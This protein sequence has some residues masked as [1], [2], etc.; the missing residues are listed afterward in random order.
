MH[1]WGS[2]A[3]A[4]AICNSRNMFLCLPRNMLL[5]LQVGLCVFLFQ[6]LFTDS[7]SVRNKFKAGFLVGVMDFL[8]YTKSPWQ[9]TDFYQEVETGEDG[10]NLS[11][12]TCTMYKDRRLRTNIYIGIHIHV[13][14]YIYLILKGHFY[15]ND[16]ILIFKHF[17]NCPVGIVHEGTWSNKRCLIR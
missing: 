17:P 8:C 1:I 15:N 13:Y 7:S 9:L 14:K 4:Y 5:W 6:V 3:P 11:Q 2:Q 10:L 16:S 12:S